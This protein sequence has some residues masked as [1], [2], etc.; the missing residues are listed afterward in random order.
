MK[1]VNLKKFEGVFYRS[2]SGN[3][4]RSYDI[5]WQEDG[6]KRWRTV[7]RASG[8]MT[9]E[10]AFRI[11]LG[12]LKETRTSGPGEPT[13]D[14][15]AAAWMPT[16]RYNSMRR[17]YSLHVAPALGECRMSELT[18]TR[19]HDLRDSLLG[20]GLAPATVCHTFTALASVINHAIE[21]ELWKGTNPVSRAAGF[22]Q[23]RLDNKGERFLTR[24]E[25]RRLLKALRPWWRDAASLTLYTGIRLG[26]IY[27]MR[28][29]DVDLGSKV[30]I[31]RGKGGERQP[32]LLV[33]EACALLERRMREH[34]RPDGL[35]FGRRKSLG[36]SRAVRRL[37]LNDGVTDPRRR[38]WY[39][40]LRHTFASWLVQKGVD[41]RAV[42]MLL[43]HKSILM[44]QRYAHLGP[45]VLRE[46]LD[47]IQGPI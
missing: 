3:T 18:R 10:E 46:R 45:Q 21:K 29:G 43:R 33:P 19:L 7:G 16:A 32:L 35:V 42:Q 28:A 17:E 6:K 47:A 22:R 37:G 13:L 27:N 8:G 23:P 20:K 12:I 24:E 9:P 14:D 30:A 11:R 5:C 40:T 39:H 41:L 2:H 25:A 34:P 44:T 26:E 38:V 4:D 15:L 36:F 1:R 31:I